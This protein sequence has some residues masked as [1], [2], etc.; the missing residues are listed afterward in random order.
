V[1]V[2][3]KKIRVEKLRRYRTFV[4]LSRESTGG[5]CVKGF[6][7]ELQV[8]AQRSLFPKRLWKLEKAQEEQAF[9]ILE[10]LHRIFSC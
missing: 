9:E 7:Q 2:P 6:R 1:Q 3:L 10:R 4:T 8:R 5:L